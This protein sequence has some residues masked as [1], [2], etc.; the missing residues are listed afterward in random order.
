MN[1]L[2]LTEVGLMLPC[3]VIVYRKDKDYLFRQY[4][5]QEPG[6]I[7]NSTL[8]EIAKDIESKLVRAIDNVNTW[9]GDYGKIQMPEVWNEVQ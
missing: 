1:P 6:M 3:N 8:K 2:K 7:N 9:R 4:C 5:R